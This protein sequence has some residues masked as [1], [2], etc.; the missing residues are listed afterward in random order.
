MSLGS[1]TVGS[2][3][4]FLEPIT[5]AAS[6]THSIKVDPGGA[7][8]GSVTLRLYETGSDI[9]GTLTVNGAAEAVSLPSPGRNASYSFAG[10]SGQQVTVRVTLS[11]FN[12][13]TGADS[14][15]TVKLVRANGTV[16]T[17]TT[18]AAASFNLTTQTLPATETY[19][20]VVDPP[21]PNVGSL[22]VSVTN[23]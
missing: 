8:T 21:G 11:D 1:T 9:A 6:G 22:T 13:P 7:S 14:T 12:L 2:L 15:V 17:S 19:T 20:V 23:P 10:T 5:L 16:L 4:G 18:S 3:G